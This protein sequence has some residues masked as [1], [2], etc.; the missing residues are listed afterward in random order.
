M[1]CTSLQYRDIDDIFDAMDLPGMEMAEI[2]LDNCELSPDDIDELFS[3]SDMPLVATCRISDKVPAA[4]AEA[5]LIRAI[6][7][8]AA[9][10]DLEIDAPAMMSKRIRREAAECGT[11]LIRSFHDW[12]GTDSRIALE[13]IIDKCA[14]LGAEIIKLVT[15]AHSQ[16]DCQRVISLYDNRKGVRLI[17]FCMGEEG[18]QT[19]ID[20]LK[21]GAPF[22]YACIDEEEATAPGQWPIAIMSDKIYGSL[23][24]AGYSSMND[25]VIF[26][27]PASKSFAQRAI[28]MAALAEGTSHLSG[29]SSCGDNDSAISVARAIGA[30]VTVSTGYT[31]N[32]ADKNISELIIKGIGAQKNCLHM[33]EMH[34]GESGFLTRMMIP[35][36]SVLNQNDTLITG[37]KTLL[38]RPLKG[39][40]EIMKAFGV[41]LS[42]DKVPLGIHGTLQDGNMEISGKDG[43]QIISGLL[44]ALPLL[45]KPTHI[46][47]KEPKSIPYIFITLDLLKK[48]GIKISNEMEGGLDFAETQD[49]NLCDSM[50]FH[51]KGGQHFQAADIQLE[52]DW[53]S[54]A[55]FMVAG[56]IFGKV[57]L[58]GLDTKSL[59]ADLSILDIL[60]EAGVSMSQEEDTGILRIQRAPLQPID[61][62]A[63]NCPDLFPIV[64]LLAAFCNG[65]SYIAGVSRL[66]GKESNRAEAILEMLQK[67]GVNV[68]L[69]KDKMVIKGQ[70]L[71]QR[72]LTGNLLKGGKYSSR[73]DHRMVMALKMAQF[74]A[75]SPI[76]IDDEVCIEKSFPSFFDL[77]KKL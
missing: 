38:E 39:A 54:A 6:Q 53:S 33:D 42:G 20:C 32:K 69:S 75:D 35:I 36:L 23:K 34:T 45:D 76:E 17:A 14:N 30:E 44:T 4:V 49:W 37:E 55:N 16:E 28:I 13:A 65:T 43:S 59:Q 47:L 73:H 52:S 22:T 5:K 31:N 77:Y 64:A 1:I 9:Y 26:N 50:N 25:E 24:M 15:T 58:T 2:R 66:V 10:A 72:L 57:A 27:M 18:R 40:E 19:R 56:A 61:I 7:A 71:C 68:H 48:F 70:S 63:D 8:G 21:K 60:M 11:I 74:G 3:E 41:Q 46:V 12:Q 29:F 62:D 51:I 67:M